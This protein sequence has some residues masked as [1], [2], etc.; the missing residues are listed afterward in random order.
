MGVP[1]TGLEHARTLMKLGLYVEARDLFLNVSNRKRL[2]DELEAQE[3]ARNEASQLANDL[4]DRIPALRVVIHN[5]PTGADVKLRIDDV[6]IPGAA[7]AFPRKVNPGQHTVRLF[8][9]GFEPV[10]RTVTVAE[11]VEKVVEVQLVA[12]D[13]DA[14]LIDPW[15]GSAEA[16]T[17]NGG[18][19]H[20]LTWVGFSFALAGLGVGAT[21]GIIAIVRKYDL[22][23]SC[24]GTRCPPSVQGELDTAL[25]IS[26]VSTVGFVVAGA[27][28][29]LG[30]TGL[31]LGASD[32]E[33]TSGFRVRPYV[34]PTA[35]GV[36]GAF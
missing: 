16:R 27:G 18:G 5:A 31:I 3:A 28:I 7:L 12:V 35:F 9:A 26:H 22:E 14:P 4:A 8:V 10:S 1:T 29:A 33:P 32:G 21:T 6:E 25:T 13:G 11:S 2:P 30:V 19:I 36:V 15:A 17:N 20:P 24:G 34:G 23:D